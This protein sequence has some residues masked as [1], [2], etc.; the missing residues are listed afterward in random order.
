MGIFGDKF[1]CGRCGE[2]S[3]PLGFAPLPT[4]LGQRI[5]AEIC[6]DCWTAWQKKQMQLINHFGIDVS[7]PES[8]QFL[9]DQMRIFFFC[10]G[11]NLAEIDTS[12][13]GKIQ[14]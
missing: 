12:K 4:E 8:H 14:W 5:G 1:K 11:V 3:E 9:F 10:E 6:K 2:K 7:D 13:E